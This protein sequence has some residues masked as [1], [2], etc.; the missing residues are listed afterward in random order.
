M[1]SQERRRSWI[2]HNNKMSGAVAALA[3]SLLLTL[4]VMSA[5]AQTFTVI[6]AFSGPDG[7]YPSAGLTADQAGNLYGT[8][9]YG[10]NNGCQQGSGCGTVFKLSRSGSGWVLSTIYEFRGGSDGGEPNARVVFGPDGSL[11]GT[12]EYFGDE[13]PTLGEGYGTV[14]KLT[15]PTHVCGSISC[16]WIHTVLYR[17]TG[18]SDGANP[19]P[20]DLNFDQ[21]GNVYGTTQAGGMVTSSCFLG[22]AGCGVVFELTPSGGGWTESVLY[23][24]TGGNDGDTPTVGVVFDQHGNLF[25]TASNGGQ[26]SYGTIYQLTPAGSGWTENTLHAFTGLEDGTFPAGLRSDGAGNVFGLAEGSPT[27]PYGG[28]AFELTPSGGSWNFSILSELPNYYTPIDAPTL[29][30]GHVYGSTFTGGTYGFGSVFE[31]VPASGG[32]TF[33][34]LYSFMAENDG[35]GPFG[36][37]LVDGSGN[38]YGTTTTGGPHSDG[39]IFQITP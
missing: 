37:V 1:R 39:V 15:P 7:N 13:S 36:S 23:S 30:N 21:A 17:F 20:G 27:L 10:G 8:T 35:D 3:I 16:P 29:H 38:V 31:L 2:F 9:S 4:S 34:S 6:H 33:V 24:F 14:F 12:T 22:S 25:G 5:E 19:G 18:G 28:V 32:W 11:Y 26:Y